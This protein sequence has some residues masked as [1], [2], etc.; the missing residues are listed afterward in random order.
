MFRRYE[1]V[2]GFL[3]AT[4]LWVVVLALASNTSLAGY[5]TA[6]TGINANAITAL[7]GL[8][9]AA[10]T[11]TLFVNAHNQLI[12]NRQVERAYV[13]ISHPSPGIEQL[14]SSGHIWFKV[15][16]KNY[17]RTPARVTNV[18]LKPVVVPHGDPLPTEPNYTTHEDPKPTAFLVTDDEFFLS[19]FY[20]ISPDEMSKVKGLL[21]DLYMIG[22]VDYVDQFD[23]HHR[24]GYA[25]QYQPMIDVKTRYKTE[26]EF[27]RRNNL[28]VVAQVGYNYDRSRS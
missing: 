16:I 14:D 19:R 28:T 15:S 22:F 21:S 1:L 11:G 10:F 2:F 13:K 9:T 17:G 8:A 4:A 23:Q 26:E 7:A 27:A 18:V 12:H 6:I 20:R 5:V 3:L 24:G 25:R